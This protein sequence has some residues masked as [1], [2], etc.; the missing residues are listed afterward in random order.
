MPV[1]CVVMPSS[2]IGEEKFS[3]EHVASIFRVDTVDYLK[4]ANPL[5]DHESA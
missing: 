5:C 3:E 1:I 4:F 2:C